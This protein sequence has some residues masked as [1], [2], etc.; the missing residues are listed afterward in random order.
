MREE[1]VGAGLR[2][3][4]ANG[5]NAAGV[6]DITDDAGVPKG[7]FYNHFDSKESLAV[8]ALQRYGEGLRLTDLADTSVEPLTRIRRNF[9]FMR[10]RVVGVD[11]R[12]GCLLGN[13]G[14]EIA[15]HSPVIRTAVHD[16]L[17]VW[18]GLLADAIAE[19]Q[20]AGAVRGSLDPHDT[21]RFLI[22]AWE[23]TMIEVR[24]SRSAAAFEP[25]FTIAF[26]V[27]L[28]AA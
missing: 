12:Q 18:G 20:A 14:V 26:G 27:L 5:Y 23:G 9:E 21:A 10:D 25:F 1:I 16:G 22:N 11:C 8:I 13:L 3:F 15:D 4:H 17:G 28:T 7:S 2:R 6:K 24:T 19:A